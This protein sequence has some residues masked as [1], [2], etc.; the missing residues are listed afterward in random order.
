ME[1]V[2]EGLEVFKRALPPSL[3]GHWAELLAGLLIFQVIVVLGEFS[4]C[5]LSC[6]V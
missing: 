5:F 4:Q 2:Y 3:A 6:S 1:V